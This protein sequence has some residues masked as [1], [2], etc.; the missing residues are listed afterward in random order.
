METQVDKNCNPAFCKEQQ[1]ESLFTEITTVE[2]G[3]KKLLELSTYSQ[4]KLIRLIQ[5]LIVKLES[6]NIITACYNHNIKSYD[7]S[8]RKVKNSY[9]RPNQIRQ[10]T[11]VYRASIILSTQNDIKIAIELIT[12]LFSKYNFEVVY[13][14]NTFEKP[15]DDGYC[16]INYKLQDIKNQMLIGELQINLYSIHKFTQDIG[17]KSYE[18]IREITD[19]KEKTI[20]KTYMNKLIKYGYDKAISVTN[21]ECIEEFIIKFTE[22]MCN[23]A[24]EIINEI[25]DTNEKT[26]IKTYMNKLNLNTISIKSLTTEN[27]RK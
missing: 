6:N 20:I 1:P 10:L 23:K 11:D 2:S 17:H 27:S 5:E 21:T 7:S 3:V 25:T 24:E 4:T 14:K 16:D 13:F 15:W 8:V 19:T 22:D 18:I 12:E 9:G 26:I